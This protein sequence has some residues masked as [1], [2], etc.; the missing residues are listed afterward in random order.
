MK[1]PRVDLDDEGLHGESGRID[2]RVE[3]PMERQG[4]SPRMAESLLGERR[5]REVQPSLLM[6]PALLAGLR[7][8]QL[9]WQGGA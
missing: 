8:A 6:L 2:W 7:Q 5:L 3:Q 1:D 4:P 9:W